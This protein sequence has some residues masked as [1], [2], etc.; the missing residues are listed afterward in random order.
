MSALVPLLVIVLP[1]VVGVPAALTAQTIH[2]ELVERESGQPVPGAFVILVDSAGAERGQALTDPSG[3]FLLRAPTAGAYHVKTAMIGWRSWV[4][5][6]LRLAPGGSVR[7]RLE[8]PLQPVRLPEIV[9]EGERRCRTDPD[10]G[11][12]IAQVWEEARKAL[13]AVSWTQQQQI[14]QYG[15][16]RYRRRLDERTLRVVDEELTTK[17]GHFRGSPFVSLPAH[18]LSRNGYV[19]PDP[20]GGWEYFGP[21]AAVLLSET[22]ANDHCFYLT[23]HAEHPRLLGLAFRP[24]RQRRVPDID[25]VL[26]LDRETAELRHLEFRYVRL[27]WSE[28]ESPHIGGRVEFERIPTGAWIVHHW[29]LRMPRL[30]RRIP[31]LLTYLRNPELVIVGYREAGGFVTDVQSADGSPIAARRG[32]VVIGAVFD[33]VTMG[34]L[35]GAVVT[36]SATGTQAQADRDGAF[37]FSDVPLGAQELAF[38]HPALDTLG[39]VPSPTPLMV[40]PGRET[41]VTLALPSHA[42]MWASLCP[43]ADPQGGGGIV[44][45]FV[46]LAEG[47]TV[48]AATVVSVAWRRWVI[49]AGER[50]TGQGYR[51]DVVTD[52]SGYYRACDV[53]AGPVT[54]AVALEDGRAAEAGLELRAGQIARADLAVGQ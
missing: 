12:A 18:E 33:S 28:I 49:H 35:S 24:V 43:G 54:V 1:L 9:V 13:S 21:D 19:R 46:R 47:D 3:R 41:R 27:P 25:G 15:L 16:V 10:T 48:A 42:S 26:W 6:V 14:L 8:V 5:P 53:P 22:F 52:R 45:G 23:E 50:L 30:G 2:G 29:W 37:R 44:A 32:G 36:I 7:Y 40:V 34:P 20:E 4:S 17:A 38:A 11:R 31:S 51:L 39:Y